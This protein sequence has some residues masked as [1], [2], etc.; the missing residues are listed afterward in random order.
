MSL[1]QARAFIDKM[2]TDDAFC[3]CVMA[4]EDVPGR[5]SIINREGFDCT[6]AEIKLVSQELRSEELD[7]VAG[8]GCEDMNYA[9]SLC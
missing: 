6:E 1:D 2:K 3:E 5:L 7:W 4:I 8:G 9:P